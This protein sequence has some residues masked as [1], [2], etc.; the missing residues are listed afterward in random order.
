MGMEAGGYPP[1]VAG[2]PSNGR[3]VTTGASRGAKGVRRVLVAAQP[4]P[5]PWKTRAAG[6]SPSRTATPGL[7]GPHRLARLGPRPI[8]DAARR[9]GG[10]SAVTPEWREGPAADPTTPRWQHERRADR[11]AGGERSLSDLAD[12]CVLTH[13]RR[14]HSERAAFLCR[15]AL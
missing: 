8:P 5:L 12:A 15:Y 7:D 10:E 1:R 6:T 14:P 3:A 13:S 4:L 11:L 9:S 2:R